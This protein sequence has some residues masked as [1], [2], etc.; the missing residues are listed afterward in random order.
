MSNSVEVVFEEELV[1]G[2]DKKSNRP[3]KNS[4]VGWVDIQED[5]E[6]PGMSA[7]RNMPVDLDDSSLLSILSEESDDERYQP[8]GALLRKDVHNIPGSP[9]AKPAGR[10]S[11]RPTEPLGLARYA[12]QVGLLAAL[13]WAIYLFIVAIW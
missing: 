8:G 5:L 13:G 2:N 3:R 1:N 11:R 4:T 10:F 9:W 6:A 12:S 7:T